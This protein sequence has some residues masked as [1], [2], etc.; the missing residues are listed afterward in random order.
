MLKF[1]CRVLLGSSH[2]L[3]F[4]FERGT[5]TIAV[6]VDF[7]DRGVVNETTDGGERYGGIRK[8]L[9][10]CAEWLVGRDEHPAVLVACADQLKK[11]GGFA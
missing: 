8:N 6:D 5:S 9:G 11:Y 3:L 7:E 1:D 2:A 4:A 10:P